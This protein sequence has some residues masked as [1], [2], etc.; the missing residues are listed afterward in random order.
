MFHI[1]TELK[2]WWRWRRHEAKSIPGSAL[3]GV[4]G[5]FQEIVQPEIR[6]VHEEQ[7]QRRAEPNQR[8]P[9]KE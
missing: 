6:Y 8:D 9:S 7:R 1:W 3:R 2:R 4:L 5:T